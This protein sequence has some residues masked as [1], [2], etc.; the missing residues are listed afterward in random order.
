MEPRTLSCE[1][2]VAIHE[3]LVADF[4][5]SGDPISPPGVRSVDLLE[6]AVWRQHT[7]LAG[8]LKYAD[9]VSNAATL[10]YGICCDH[11]FHNGNKRTALVAMLVHLDDNRLA[12]YDTSQRELYA[13]I[14][15]V[16]D[17]ALGVRRDPRR[18]DKIPSR[19][20]SDEE[21]NAVAEWIR[22]RADRVVR[23]ERQLTYRE[24]RRLL[25]NFGFYL[26]NPDGNYIDV[27]RHEER[28]VG[29]MRKR[30]QRVSKR[31][32]NIGWP[33]EHEVV[34]VGEIKRI[35]R[36]LRLTESEGVDSGAFYDRHAVI[37]EFVNRYRTLLR[38]LARR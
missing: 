28:L 13:M 15:A 7:S 4:A 14:I 38:R 3:A 5:G 30:V 22:R 16:A 23:G 24:F 37:D 31:V 36:L 18:P 33:G 34:G 35:R 1:D 12:L 20:K 9:T 6:S 8:R 29:F 2:V 21:V 27:V 10:L 11:P 19:R 25:E 26:E 17:H 32:A